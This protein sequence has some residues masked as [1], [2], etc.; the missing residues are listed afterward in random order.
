MRNILVTGASRGIGKTIAEELDGNIFIT[1]RDEEAL[2]TINAI[3]YC[4]CDLKT[5]EKLGKFIE[6]NEID[7][8][9]NNAGEYI[10]GGIESMSCAQINEIFATNL[11]APAYLSA[12]A[13][14]HMKKQDWG[15][16]V[17]IG[18]IS[19]VMGEANASLYSASKS[20]LIGLSKA[21]A[22]E[23]AADNITVNIINPGWVETELG[24]QSIED[25]DFDVQCIPQ[26]RFIQPIEVANLVKYLISD[27][28]KGVTGQSIN[29]CAGLSVGY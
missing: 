10:Y 15:R 3:A 29:L 6:D 20:G 2:K 25:S 1:G 14:K 18:S 17:N 28:A 13:V 16:I 23:L 8:L 27:E 21:L 4:A 5:P 24:I 11:H 19:G 9:I 26:K 7:I 22:L 12:C